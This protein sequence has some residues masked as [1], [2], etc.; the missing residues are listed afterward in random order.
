MVEFEE[1][2]SLLVWKILAVPVSFVLAFF[3][4]LENE[5]AAILLIGFG[6]LN[7][8]SICI[9]YVLDFLTGWYSNIVESCSDWDDMNFSSLSD[10]QR[11]Y[12]L[13]LVGLIVLFIVSSVCG[14]FLSI[15]GQIESFSFGFWVPNDL[16]PLSWSSSAVLGLGVSLL[17][18]LFAVVPGEEGFKNCFLVINKAFSFEGLPFCLQPCRLAANFFWALLHVVLG[19]NNPFFVVSVFLAG[20][21]MD[22][23]SA[24]SGTIENNYRIHALF[25][26]IIIIGS[27]VFSGVLTIVWGA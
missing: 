3:T 16:Y 22:T 18:T 19:Q 13:M 1:S 26:S 2:P 27:F 25:N 11:S 14:F 7:L 6:V 10:A 15:T 23:V 4:Y 8:A 9:V 17:S 24:R 20:C 5:S 12:V 21:I